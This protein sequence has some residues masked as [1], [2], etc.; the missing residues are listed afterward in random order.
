MIAILIRSLLLVC[1]AVL[2]MRLMGKR[3]IGQLQ[4]F[5]LVIA[6]MIADLASTPMASLD[7]PLWHGIMPLFTTV[8]LYP[9][10]LADV[11]WAVIS[12]AVTSW[13]CFLP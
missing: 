11:K 10:A 8:A 3:Q 2:A 12:I 5:E 13:I 1:A 6:I 7:I 4:P 9:F